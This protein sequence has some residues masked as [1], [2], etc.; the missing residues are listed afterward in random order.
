SSIR[1]GGGSEPSGGGFRDRKRTRRPFRASNVPTHRWRLDR[2]RGALFCDGPG[3]RH[4]STGSGASDDETLRGDVSSRSSPSPVNRFV[5]VHLG[6][7]FV[8][9]CVTAWFSYAYF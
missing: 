6:V 3:S 2:R 1:I 9:T 7:T 4:S 8:V 5:R